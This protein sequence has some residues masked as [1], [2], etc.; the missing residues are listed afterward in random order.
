VTITASINIGSDIIVTTCV[1][2]Y[3]SGSNRIGG[4]FCIA[5]E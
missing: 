4:E 3:G 2:G 5:D 1:F